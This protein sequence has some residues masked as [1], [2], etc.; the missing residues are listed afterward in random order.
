MTIY[1]T[2]TL[3]LV[4][5]IWKRVFLTYNRYIPLNQLFSYIPHKWLRLTEINKPDL[6]AFS[7]YYKSSCFTANKE[8]LLTEKI[9]LSFKFSM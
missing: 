8:V 1:P 4:F 5:F 9:D 6:L 7:L 3:D 2:K